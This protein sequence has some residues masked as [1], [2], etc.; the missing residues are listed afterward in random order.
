MARK[1]IFESIKDNYD[2]FKEIK[3]IYDNIDNYDI[4]C[5]FSKDKI[6]GEEVCLDSY[7]LFDFCDIYLYEFLPETST[8]RHIEEFMEYADAKLL[9]GR[10]YNVTE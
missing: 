4:F 6:T 10:S 8:C 9:F 2:I 1:N 3:K 5:R 7:K